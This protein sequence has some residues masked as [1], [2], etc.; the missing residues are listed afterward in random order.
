[1]GPEALNNLLDRSPGNGLVHFLLNFAVFKSYL[2]HYT[3]YSIDVFRLEGQEFKLVCQIPILD[4][5]VHNRF[6]LTHILGQNENIF[7][8]E[9]AKGIENLREKSM[10]KGMGSL[11]QVNKELKYDT[12]VFIKCRNQ[13]SVRYLNSGNKMLSKNF[14]VKEH[15]VKKGAL[16]K[17]RRGKFDLFWPSDGFVT[18]NKIQISY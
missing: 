17:M 16:Q 13:H 8:F 14:M 15:V 11:I 6:K 9:M 5:Y 4:E 3:R 7:I 12:I 10:E 18:L 1:M 2:I